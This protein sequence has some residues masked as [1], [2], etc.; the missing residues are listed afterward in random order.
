MERSLI[1]VIVPVYNVEKYLERCINS[2]INQT[3]QNL[4]IILVDDGSVDNSPEICDNYAKKYDYIKVIHKKNGGLSSARNT[5]IKN[6]TGNYIGFVDSDD[7]IAPVMFEK[8][9]D[10]INRYKLKIAGVNFKSIKSDKEI[11]L[12]KSRYNIEHYDNINALYHLFEKEDYSV[13][14]K[15]YDKNL[16]ENF[17]FKENTIN[18]DILANYFLF[19][20]SNGFVYF[21]E[22]M[23]YY[24]NNEGSITSSKFKERDFDLLKN[25]KELLI[26][27]K[28]DFPD[29]KKIQKLIEIKLFRSYFS[30]LAKIA[31]FGFDFNINKKMQNEIIKFLLRHLRKHY[32]QLLFSKIALNRKIIITIFCLNYHQIYYLFEYKRKR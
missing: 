15:L 21:N 28:K 18:E 2:I 13:C 3:Y 32:F 22:V 16:F 29:C 12:K 17:M 1:S 26:E 20:K 14:N 7:S 31:Y 8:L 11:L 5:G 9:L 6:S 19:S 4:E 23:Y 30:L 27:A 10:L 24:F 25:C